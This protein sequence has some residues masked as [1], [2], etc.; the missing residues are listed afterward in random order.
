M[1]DSRLRI[2]TDK[3]HTDISDNS[4]PH[5]YII[6]QTDLEGKDSSYIACL[7]SG[8]ETRVGYSMSDNNRPIY[9][10]ELIKKLKNYNWMNHKRIY[11]DG[12]D[13]RIYYGNSE[14]F[15]PIYEINTYSIQSESNS[16]L[17]DNI[18][19]FGFKKLWEQA[20]S[21]SFPEQQEYNSKKTRIEDMSRSKEIYFFNDSKSEIDFLN[22]S[23]NL[24]VL[25]DHNSDTYT[26]SVDIRSILSG[27]ICENNITSAKVDL[28]VQ[29]SKQLDN[30]T[31]VITHDTTFEGFSIMNGKLVMPNFTE[32]I[33]EDVLVEF[34]GGIIRVFPQN[35]RVVE[36]IIN[37]CSVIYGNFKH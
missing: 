9:S 30:S 28:S 12:D 15:N 10:S 7:D 20:F 21:N 25:V 2:I 18:L 23:N 36:C 29:F 17:S 32:T 1:K 22:E 31:V 37:N 8:T 3:E 11:L 34:V 19:D 13:I 33:G 27:K 35:D 24:A 5:I 14:Q 16:I 4:L 6:N 26:N